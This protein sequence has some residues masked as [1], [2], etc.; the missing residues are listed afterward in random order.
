[1]KSSTY[2]VCSNVPAIFKQ[3]MG[4]LANLWQREVLFASASYSAKKSPKGIYPRKSLEHW[5]KPLLL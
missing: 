2:S 1:M 3:D 5:N 4:N